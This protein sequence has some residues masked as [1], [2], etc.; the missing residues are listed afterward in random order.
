VTIRQFLLEYICNVSSTPPKNEQRTIKT[1]LCS[2]EEARQKLEEFFKHYERGGGAD[3]RV[4]LVR[5]L[6]GIR[7]T[8][9]GSWDDMS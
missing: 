8:L 5:G 6:P 9:V 1:E 7:F 2:E 4:E 3:L